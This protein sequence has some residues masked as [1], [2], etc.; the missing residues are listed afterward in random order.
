MR[1]SR[2]D[3]SVLCIH[4][5]TDNHALALEGLGKDTGIPYIPAMAEPPSF[6]WDDTKA[7][8]NLLK[9]GVPFAYASRVYLDPAALD[10]D[11]TNPADGEQRRKTVGLIE[12]RLFTVV[13]TVRGE[14]HR[15][16]SARRSNEKERR[17]YGHR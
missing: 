10:Y 3:S 9:H 15:L 8:S 16:I 12:G 5:H 17:Y 1:A 2:A 4:L 13:Y 11:A 6:E 14:T 7:E